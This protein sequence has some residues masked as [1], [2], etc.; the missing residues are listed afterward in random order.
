MRKRMMSR[1]EMFTEKECVCVC[2]CVCVCLCDDTETDRQRKKV[3]GV[4]Q[5]TTDRLIASKMYKVR[6]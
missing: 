4:T 1:A 5:T 6:H 2:V 3:H